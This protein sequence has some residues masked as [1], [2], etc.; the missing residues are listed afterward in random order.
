MKEKKENSIVKPYAM[1]KKCLYGCSILSFS[2]YSLAILLASLCEL[3]EPFIMLYH[4]GNDPS[5]C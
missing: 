4:Q 2:Y 5:T 1:R 3:E